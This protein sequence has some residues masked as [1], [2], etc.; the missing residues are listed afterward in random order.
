MLTADE[1]EK[2]LAKEGCDK[3]SHRGDTCPWFNGA[4]PKLDEFFNKSSTRRTY[5]ALLRAVEGLL[6]IVDESVGVE[7]WHLNE[8]IAEWGEFEFVSD[9]RQALALHSKEAS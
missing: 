3:H 2:L 6:G 1:L 9:A 7:G 4:L 8:A 5:A